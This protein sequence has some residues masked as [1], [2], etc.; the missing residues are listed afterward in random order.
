MFVKKIMMTGCAL[1]VIAHVVQSQSSAADQAPPA[2]LFS[3]KPAAPRNAPAPAAQVRGTDP[4]PSAAQRASATPASTTPWQFNK[5]KPSPSLQG[6]TDAPADG[7][8]LSALRYYAAQND[9]ARVSAEIKLLRSHHPDWQPPDDLFTDTAGSADE[10]PLW[11]LLA[12]GDLDGVRDGIAAIQR[13]KAEWQ[14]SPDLRSKLAEAEARRSLAAASDAGRWGDVVAIAS[15]N[16][17]LLTCSNVDLLWRT[18]EAL[19]RN[20]DEARANDA[21]SYILATCQDP[22]ERLATVQK[23]SLVL[24]APGA[25]DQLMR[26]GRRSSDGHSEF[27]PV[28]VALLRQKIGAAGQSGVSP[29]LQ[30]LDEVRADFARTRDADDADTLAWYAYSQKKYAE[31]EAWFRDAMGVGDSPK[32]TEGLALA[33][34][35][36]QRV[37][38]AEKLLLPRVETDPAVTKLLIEL[39]EASIVDPKA[40]AP[41][42]EV[43]AAFMRGMEATHSAE[44]AQAYGW[45]L[46]QAGQTAVAYDWFEKSNGWR[47]NESAV[48]GLLVSSK[49]LKRDTVYRDLI[50]RYSPVYA[51]VGQLAALMRPRGPVGRDRPTVTAAAGPRGTSKA[52][53][54]S[55][56]GE[57]TKVHAAVR[58]AAGGG[59]WD[60]D[61]DTIVAT[62]EGGDYDRAVAMLDSRRRT[63]SE[64]SGLALIR[65]WAQYHRGDWDGA[66]QTFAGLHDSE[67]L[68]AREGLRVV[69]DAFTPPR[70]R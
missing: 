56:R 16:G 23:A 43:M 49:R 54:A 27:E 1:F 38:E 6:T 70:M 2:D 69:Q 32:R 19:A 65:G 66:K 53:V 57:R 39:V 48:I 61:A 42:A 34:R 68:K 14:P 8:D 11:D 55:S 3:A 12:K 29:T 24:K 26:Q 31:A 30:D 58:G 44:G 67:F 63:K 33:L 59:G 60:K 4:A 35:D 15:K 13:D 5:P 18:A 41:T 46:Y 64:P 17:A 10:Q 51:K 40:A 28:R 25:L 52:V 20:G 36:E 22:Q 9:L 21:Y 62:Y 47:A 7:I 45:H 50:A 37:A